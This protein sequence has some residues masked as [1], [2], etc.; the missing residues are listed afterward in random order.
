MNLPLIRTFLLS[1][2]GI[3]L[4]I[5]SSY[6]Q[7]KPASIYAK[8]NL[9]AWCIVP[10]DSK[11]RGPVERAEMLNKLGITRLAYD[12]R[13][14]H[15]PTF[16]E[17][18]EAC[19][20]HHIKLEAFWMYSGPNPEQDQGLQAVLDVLKRKKVKTQIWLMIGGIKNMNE[21]SQE[22]K[23]K[24]VARPVQY[25]VERA[26]ALGCTVGLYNHGGWFGEPENQLAVID[27]LKKP[28]LGMVYNFHHA[29]EH[30][31]RFP[32]FFPKILPHLLAL[33]LAGLKKGNPV[34][35]VPIGDGDAEQGMMEVVKKSGYKGPIGIINEDTAPDAEVGLTLNMKGLQKVLQ[36]MGDQ[37]ALKSYQ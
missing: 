13:E 35:V 3:M 27:Y 36:A 24:A 20:S 37:Q 9:V 7:R 29:E 31:E 11:N 30:I 5:T 1:F 25:V 22:E 16:D 4:S 26:A 10:F 32:Q 28:N 23:I 21:M 14:K 17:E 15:I 8:D 33:N 18:I 12:W 19:R 2:L 34:K 6:A